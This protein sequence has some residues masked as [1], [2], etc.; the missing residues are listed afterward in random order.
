MILDPDVI[1]EALTG[2]AV[3]WEVKVIGATASTNTT[4]V[5]WGRRG[6]KAPFALFTEVQTQGRGRRG[7][8]WHSVAGDSLIA[9][10]LIRPDSPPAQW[11]LVTL[12]TG[13][14]LV[15]AL[16]TTA[17]V[18]LKWPNDLIL[19]G[20]KLGG[21]LVETQMSSVDGFLVIGFGINLNQTTFDAEIEELAISLRQH[22]NQQVDLNAIAAKALNALAQRLPEAWNDPPRILNRFGELDTLHGALVTAHE[23]EAGEEIQG[24]AQG[25]DGQGRLILRLSSGGF[26]ALEDAWSICKTSIV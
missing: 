9:S 11:R 12:A 2:A 6:A 19:D 25:I 16:T 26:R 24:V 23:R 8:A 17:P 15:D 1:S 3:G 20:K 5:D 14:A 4:L 18:R 13:I 7:R 10:V 22:T 21:I